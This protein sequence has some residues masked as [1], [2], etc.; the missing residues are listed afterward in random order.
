MKL[1]G[2]FVFKGI[3]LEKP[4]CT[5]LAAVTVPPGDWCGKNNRTQFPLMYYLS[6]CMYC[7]D[8]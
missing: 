6:S 2:K 7:S 4:D 1:V 8:F 3:H 5:D